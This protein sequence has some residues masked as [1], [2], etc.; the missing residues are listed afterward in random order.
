MYNSTGTYIV[1]CRILLWCLSL[2]IAALQADCRILL[3]CLSLTIA[4]L[5]A[6]CRILF[7][8]LSLTIA[9]LQADLTLRQAMNLY[10]WV[11]WDCIYCTLQYSTQLKSINISGPESDSDLIL[12]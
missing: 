11:G 5:Q 4:V 1:H 2:T 8:C 7:W 9:V 10:G 12:F 3:W 6:D